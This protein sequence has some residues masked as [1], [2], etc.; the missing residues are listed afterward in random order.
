MTL[1]FWSPDI[2]WALG[3][4]GTEVKIQKKKIRGP[5]LFSHKGFTGPAILKAS[6]YWEA[7]LAVSINWL[8]DIN[9]REEFERLPSQTQPALYL[10][11]LLP[12]RMVDFFLDNYKIDPKKTLNEISKKSLNKL[13]D[14][15]QHFQFIPTSSA[16]YD[17][18]EVTKG[19]VNTKEIDSKSMESKL[20]P[21]LYF[22]GEVLDVTG[23]LGGFNFQWAWAS[24]NAAATHLKSDSH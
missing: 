21:R 13:I 10:K 8:P 20:V 7:G 2:N 1:I 3:F 5:V 24:A 17:R 14:G 22:I 9:L 23:Q 18:A 11:K 4:P 6:L 15:L 12:A 16:G 19:G